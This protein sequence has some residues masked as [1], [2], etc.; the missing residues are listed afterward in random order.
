MEHFTLRLRTHYMFLRLDLTLSFLIKVNIG[1][2]DPE[3]PLVV[4]L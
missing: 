1:S 3:P 4:L 2:G